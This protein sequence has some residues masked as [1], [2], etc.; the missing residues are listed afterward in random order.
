MALLEP[1]R[2]VLK[3]TPLD[4]QVQIFG[5]AEAPFIRVQIEVDRHQTTDYR[6]QSFASL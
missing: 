2:A 6:C 4:P 5:W 1:E 3:F